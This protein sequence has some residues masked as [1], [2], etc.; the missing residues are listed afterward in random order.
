MVRLPAP[1]EDAAEFERRYCGDKA[2]QLLS[3]AG[4]GHNF[5][6]FYSRAISASRGMG[7]APRARYYN[8]EVW[9]LAICHM[10]Y[11]IWHMAY[12][13]SA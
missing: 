11:F 3:S 5:S 1:S 12:G 4:V 9:S 6:L 2:K 7:Q 8:S 10:P 13:I